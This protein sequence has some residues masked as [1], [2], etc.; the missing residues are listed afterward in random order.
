MKIYAKASLSVEEIEEKIRC[1]C[2]GIEYNLTSDFMT[3]GGDFLNNYPKEVFHM[4]N[5][6]VVHTPYDNFKQ[7]MN[8]ER[9]FLHEDLS[10]V[11]NV[12]RLAQYLADYWKHRIKVVIHSSL[13]MVDFMEYEILRKRMESAFS[14]YFREYPDVDLVIENVVPM[15]FKDTDHPHPRLY[16]GVFLDTPLMAGYFRDIFGERVGTVLD[17]CHAM[18]TEKYLSA[19]L[20]AA[21]FLPEGV[22]F[23]RMGKVAPEMD[24]S[25][26]HYFESNAGMCKLIHFNDFVGNGYKV[27][28]GTS[29]DSQ[30]KVDGLLKL[31]HDYGYDCP[32]TLE[33]REDDYSNCVNYRKTKGLIEKSRFFF[34]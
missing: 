30:E 9:A 24:L 15:E 10:P 4:H 31:Y 7:M 5:V 32:L 28:H 22:S 12:F 8:M 14:D 34:A 6:E 27:N 25:M 17:T 1:G 11:E 26:E 19:L 20:T 29:F 13:S 2:D 3:L 23:D 18:M 21:D 33:I 16:N